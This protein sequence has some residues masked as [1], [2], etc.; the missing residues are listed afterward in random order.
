LERSRIHTGLNDYQG[1]SVYPIETFAL[2]YKKYM[3][4]YDNTS[5]SAIMDEKVTIRLPKELLTGLDTM[6]GLGE[7]ASRSEAVRECL[8]EKMSQRLH[9]ADVDLEKMQLQVPA[10]FL[11]DIDFLVRVNYYPSRE[12]AILEALKVHL[13]ETLDLYRIKTRAEHMQDIGIELASADLEKKEV[14]KIVKS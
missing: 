13:F 12:A 2:S 8:K 3:D 7:Y 10:Q 5:D 1:I 4:M 14:D 6:V 11:S 9:G